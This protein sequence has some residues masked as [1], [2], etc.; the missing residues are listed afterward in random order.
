VSYDV[1]EVMED[2]TLQG[3]REPPIQVASRECAEQLDKLTALLAMVEDRLEPIRRRGPEDPHK[4]TADEP[5][6]AASRL[7][8]DLQS[9][10]DKI[11]QL[12]R[13]FRVLLEELEL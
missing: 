8:M 6:P 7:A 9:Y 1:R 4:G 3:D 10:T 13:R 5:R 12:Q 2:P 11:R